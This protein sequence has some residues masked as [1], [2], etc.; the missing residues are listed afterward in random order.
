MAASGNGAAKA[1]APDSRG[2]AEA[3]EAPVPNRVCRMRPLLKGI[4]RK[5]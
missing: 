1:S 3:G 5:N 4:R 2:T